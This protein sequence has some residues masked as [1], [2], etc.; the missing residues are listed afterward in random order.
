MAT[1]QTKQQLADLRLQGILDALQEQAESTR[2]N[3][4][5]FEERL[6]LLVE[7]E[8]VRRRD[9]AFNKRIKD[10]RFKQRAT[11][12]EIDFS[13]KRKLDKSQ[14]L[15]LAQC[16]WILEKHNIIVSGPTGVGKTFLACALATGACRQ[17]FTA[18]Y[19]KASTLVSDLA[20]AR[21]EGAH[22]SLATKLAKVDVLIIDEWLR[23]P[24]QHTH[25]RDLLDLL[26]DRYRYAST[27]LVS[28]IPVSDWH[29]AILSPT[30]ADAILDR[31]VHD[32]HR[33]ELKGDSMR[34][35]TT[36]LTREHNQA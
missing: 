13:Q 34:K 28:Q 7:R 33:V 18:L 11:I 32:S 24:L 5:S 23:D 8:H 3:E 1:T 36:T 25:A 22:H 27:I 21:A 20:V 4:L 9:R 35:E 19:T 6:A 26:D 14:L 2:Y 29:S 15:S 12:E 30:V 31:L 10:A 17:G 16:T